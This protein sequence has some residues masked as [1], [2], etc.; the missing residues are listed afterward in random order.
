MLKQCQ[1]LIKEIDGTSL[2][3]NNE[4]P[5]ISLISL[6][7]WSQCVPASL[8][9]EHLFGPGSWVQTPERRIHVRRL[10]P[11]ALGG[12]VAAAAALPGCHHGNA[13]RTHK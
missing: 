13:S 9:C 4:L 11:T 5:S 8:V 10:S 3:I 6:K 2:E 12:H 1:N 7:S